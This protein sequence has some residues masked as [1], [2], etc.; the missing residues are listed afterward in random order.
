MKKHI[1]QTPDG[2]Y[3]EYVLASL[4]LRFYAFFIDQL[5]II[6]ITSFVFFSL[7]ILSLISPNLMIFLLILSLFA[8]QQGYFIFFETKWRGQT[9][10]KRVFN[11]QVVD[12]N[13]FQITFN[14]IFI[15]NILRIVDG[16]PQFGLLGGIVG[17]FSSSNKRLGDFAADTV[18][19]DVSIKK[20]L[21]IQSLPVNKYNSF[22]KYPHLCAKIRKQIKPDEVHLI[23][24]ILFRKESVDSSNIFA[25]YN[26][27]KSYFQNKIQ[28][29]QDEID[30]ISSEQYLINLLNVVVGRK[31]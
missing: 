25:I 27:T 6:S 1:I 3:F 20:I 9:P 30:T 12:S 28:I 17:F 26:E 19:I 8:I 23:F 11:I 16:L 21:P 10:G 7:N 22:Y 4:L 14:Q 13:G 5:L 31:S 15:R 18:V 29:P 24:E 2:V